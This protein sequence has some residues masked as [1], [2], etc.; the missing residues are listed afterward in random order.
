MRRVLRPALISL[1]ALALA[2]L[3]AELGLRFLLFSRSSLALRLG[4]S[5]RKAEWYADSQNEDA[6]WKLVYLFTDPKRWLGAFRPSPECGWT[7]DIDPLTYL[8]VPPVDL[9]ARRPILLYGDSYAN[10][11]TPEGQCFEDI[12]ERTDLADR[13][14]LVNYGVGG[15]GVDLELILLRRSIDLWK[16]RDP[17]VVLSFLVDD[18]FSRDI[19]SF[20]SSPKPRFRIADDGLEIVPPDVLDEKEFIARNPVGIRSYLWRLLLFR[21]GL[22]PKALVRRVHA[23]I[24]RRQEVI[25]LG[26]RILSE[27]HRELESRGLQHFFLVFQGGQGLQPRPGSEWVETFVRQ[28]L[29]RL[30]EHSIETRP[31]L[32]AAADGSYQVAQSRLIGGTAQT[33]GHYNELGNIVAFEALRQGIEGRFDPIDTSGVAG[34]VHRSPFADSSTAPIHVCGLPGE[35]VGADPT[36]VVRWSKTPYPPFDAAQKK[37]YLLLRPGSSGRAGV[38]VVLFPE[39]YRRVLGRAIASAG[40][41]EMSAGQLS[42]SIRLD[43]REVRRAS[44]PAWPQGLDLDVDLAGSREVEIEASAVGNRA[45]AACVHIGDLRFE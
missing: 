13:Y 14:C 31:Y 40:K 17:I 21:R 43:G 3:C 42:L 2:I 39:R 35:P 1:L 30:G 41:K 12:L 29:A 27:M 11:N 4:E 34:I 23:T 20:R 28:T 32:L 37:P 33:A 10:C 24:D 38:R 36:A 44:V 5:W 6:Y 26:E 25:A 15:Y 16:D 18:D 8:P 7:G 22:L 19:L 45:E 9:R